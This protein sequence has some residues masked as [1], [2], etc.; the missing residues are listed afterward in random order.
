MQTECMFLRLQPWLQKVLEKL[1]EDKKD[2][3]KTKSQPALKFLVGKVKEL[4]LCAPHIVIASVKCLLSLLVK[5]CL[6]RCLCQFSPWVSS[7]SH[8]PCAASLA[9]PWTRRAQWCTPTTRTAP[10]T[11]HSFTPGGTS[12]ILMPAL[13]DVMTRRPFTPCVL[14]SSFFLDA[15]TH[16]PKRRPSL[17]FLVASV[18]LRLRRLIS[19]VLL[20]HAQPGV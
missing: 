15:A 5:A 18:R 20:W 3:F 2:E 1:P 4:Q 9:S 7:C 16:L 17:V 8:M 19:L 6:G 10:P 12:N 13:L 14:I 11:R